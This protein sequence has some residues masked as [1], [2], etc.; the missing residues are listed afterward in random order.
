MSRLAVWLEAHGR[1]IDWATRLVGIAGLVVAVT[2]YA[3]QRDYVQCQADVNE[4]LIARSRVLTEASE[5]ER[6]AQ[7]AA[8]DATR[9]LF[10]DPVL[11]KPAR[12]RTAAEQQRLADLFAGYQTAL[13]NLDHERM[14]ADQARAANPVPAPPSQTCG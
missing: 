6:T 12:D 3:G 8:E 10:T 14:Q 11:T 7:R 13:T 4:A 9:E 5:Q 2:L 1:L